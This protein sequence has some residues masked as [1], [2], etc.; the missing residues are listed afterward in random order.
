MADYKFVASSGVIIPDLSDTR[1]AVVAE[2]RAV[3][4]AD[5]AVDPSTPQGKLITRIS[6]ERD[7]IARNNAELAN[8]INPD[9][10]GG[11]HL[12]ALFRLTG[13][14]R[15][16]AEFS[17]L[18][19]VQLTGIP[20][21]LVPAGSQAR[22]QS[23]AV[24]ALVR[25]V[26]IGSSGSVQG[27]FQA[28]EPGPIAAPPNTLDTVASNVLGWEGVNNPF[29]ASLGRLVESDAAAR[30][31]RRQT[32]ALQTVSTSE[33]I[34]SRLYDLPLVRSVNY[35]EN[36]KGEEQVID[37]ITLAPHSVWVCV[38]EGINSD[39]GRVLLDTKTIG[40][41]YNGDEVVTVEEPITGREYEI[42]F[43]RPDVIQVLI[44]VTVRESSLDLTNLIPELIMNYV[45]G[46]VEG[47]VS[48]MVG[49]DVSP[50][51]IAGAINQQEPNIHVRKVELSVVGSGVWS[52]DT[53]EV[54]AKG[55][56]R[57]VPSSISVVFV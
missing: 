6:E 52:T 45:D 54:G 8:Q 28:I 31:R 44:R 22:T 50:F 9:L 25:P 38:E 33:A 30:R 24:F 4:G 42:R 29:A 3:F 20:R 15:R 23:G 14:R 13:G 55:V 17:T 57:T 39:I 34:I 37:G 2:F 12:D 21:T 48:F 18:S 32:L 27:A 16:G 49:V 51:E 7:A 35:I 19:E 40:A 5:L 36:F 46:Q 53:L 1:N 56:A 43:D 26:Q 10:A 47:D 11:V 41:A